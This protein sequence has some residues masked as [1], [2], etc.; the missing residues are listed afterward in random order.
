METVKLIEIDEKSRNL[1]LEWIMGSDKSPVNDLNP[2][3]YLAS[4]QKQK[5]VRDNLPKR[6][7]S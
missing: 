7:I 2:I 1:I 3:F 5:I 4:F 6:E